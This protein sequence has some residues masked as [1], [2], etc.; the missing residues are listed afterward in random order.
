MQLHKIL[1]TEI[2]ETVDITQPP[3]LWEHEASMFK[4]LSSFLVTHRSH[5][6]RYSPP[7]WTTNPRVFKL[8]PLVMTVNSKPPVILS[9]TSG[10][11][12]F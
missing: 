9:R 4:L 12:L 8:E 11:Q 6:L 5:L 7:I 10:Y 1:I 3:T 2:K